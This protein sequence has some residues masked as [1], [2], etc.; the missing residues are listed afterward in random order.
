MTVLG[1]YSKT[2]FLQMERREIANNRVKLNKFCWKNLYGGRVQVE[3][4]ATLRP[5][6]VFELFVLQIDRI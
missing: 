5:P 3:Y 6:V 4:L 2:Y 1:L